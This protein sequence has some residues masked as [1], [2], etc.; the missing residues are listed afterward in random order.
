M[1]K[2]THPANSSASTKPSENFTQ[3]CY[4]GKTKENDSGLPYTRAFY[5]L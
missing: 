4:E 5:V 1:A 2:V 3:I